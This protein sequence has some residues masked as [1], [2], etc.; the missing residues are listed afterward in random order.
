[1]KFTQ[2]GII[3]H[4]YGQDVY[5]LVKLEDADFPEAWEPDHAKQE[6]MVMDAMITRYYR[7]SDGAGTR[8]CTEFEV[9]RKPYTDEFVTVAKVRYDI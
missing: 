4:D 9:I 7:E 3:P 8:Y 6:E 5:N 2:I 1:M